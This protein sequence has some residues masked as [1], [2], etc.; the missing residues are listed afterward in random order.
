NSTVDASTSQ[1]TGTANLNYSCE[2]IQIANGAFS[3]TFAMV[4][5]RKV[6]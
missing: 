3:N 4:S 5:W 1:F 2:G 6:E